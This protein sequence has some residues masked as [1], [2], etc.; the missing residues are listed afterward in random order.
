[1]ARLNGFASIVSELRA[2]RTKLENQLRHVEAALS[3]LTALNGRGSAARTGRTISAAARKRISAAQKARWAKARQQ[4][5]KPSA[6]IKTNKTPV[7]RTMPPAARR[8]IAAFQ[9]SRW[10]KVR[11]QQGQQKKAA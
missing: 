11:A 2:K 8:K 7:K 5:S 6:E 1:M 9:R 4:Q 3:A 10:A